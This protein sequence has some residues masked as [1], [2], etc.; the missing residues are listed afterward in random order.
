MSE[1]ISV[2]LL[3]INKFFITLI[4]LKLLDKFLRYG[5]LAGIEHKSILKKKFATIV[6]I[7]ANKGQFALASR[8]YT[9]A[10]IISFEPLK[11]PAE[12]FKAVFKDDQNISL[13]QNAVG[14]KKISS[15]INVCYDNDSSSLLEVGKLQKL[16]FNSKLVSTE[17][18]KIAPLEDVIDESSISGPALLKIDVQG[19]EDNVIDGCAS[20]IHKFD[21]IY[22]ECSFVEL[23]KAQTLASEIVNKLDSLGFAMNDVQNIYYWKGNAIQADLLFKN[24]SMTQ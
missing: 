4:N 8:F 15:T 13:F 12:I 1:I 24:K 17:A 16:I 23:Y 19:F 22:C 10:K 7:G 2:Y 3:K 18:I 6:D 14:P 11:S 5:V 21:Y 9:D 20:I